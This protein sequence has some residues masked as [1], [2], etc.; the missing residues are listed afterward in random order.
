MRKNL[1]K[2]IVEVSML[3][4]IAL[5]FD[6]LCGNFLGFAWLNGGSISIAAIPILIASYK[7]SY[8]GGLLC[9]LLV[10]TI[11]L[12]WTK[13]N[14]L[15]HP[16]QIMLDYTLPYLLVGGIGA[17]SV[18][19]IKNTENKNLKTILIVLGVLVAFI[20]K[21][22]SQTLSGVWF[23]ETPF[24]PSLVYNGTYNALSCLSCIILII[25][26]SFNKYIME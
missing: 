5:V 19:F 13:P 22:L 16:I 9:G 10:G 15:I 14:L 12:L 26:L 8:K 3:S 21:T 20:F 6:L 11:Q 17:L 2:F 23:W 25:P 1:I 7:Y 4:A 24:I 18:C